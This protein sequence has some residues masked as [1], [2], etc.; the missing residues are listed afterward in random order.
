M[1][2]LHED[3]GEGEAIDGMTSD[4]EC[5]SVDID[6]SRESKCDAKEETAE[7]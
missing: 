5:D 4:D 6:I 2:I 1:D 3:D 7:V